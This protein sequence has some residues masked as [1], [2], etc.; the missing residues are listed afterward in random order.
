M[1]PTR[2]PVPADRLVSWWLEAK[3]EGFTKYVEQEQQR[4]MSASLLGKG[5]NRVVTTV[6]DGR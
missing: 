2:Q 5:R 4:R 6:E 3:P 1:K